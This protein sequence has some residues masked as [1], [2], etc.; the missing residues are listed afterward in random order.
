MLR[1]KDFSFERGSSDEK[2]EET[3]VKSPIFGEDSS[4]KEK[5]QRSVDL[6]P[7]EVTLLKNSD[8]AM[9]DPQLDI[10]NEGRA[11]PIPVKEIKKAGQKPRRILPYLPPVVKELLRWSVHPDQVLRGA[12]SVSYLFTLPVIEEEALPT[13]DLNETIGEPGVLKKKR[14]LPSIP[15]THNRALPSKVRS[16]VEQ[17]VLKSKAKFRRRMLPTLPM[18]RKQMPT[19]PT[20]EKSK[21]IA[22]EERQTTYKSEVKEE[23]QSLE[24]VIGR[25]EHAATVPSV[26]DD[27]PKA[28]RENL[29]RLPLGSNV[30]L[31]VRLPEELPSV[32]AKLARSNKTMLERSERRALHSKPINTR[33][34]LPQITKK[35]QPVQ[36]PLPTVT[37][38][39]PKI[40]PTV[41]RSTPNSQLLVSKAPSSLEPTLKGRSITD[42]PIPGFQTVQQEMRPKPP[43]TSKPNFT[44]PRPQIPVA[45]KPQSS[46]IQVANKQTTSIL[47]SPSPKRIV[48]QPLASVQLD[49][50]CLFRSSAET[51]VKENSKPLLMKSQVDMR[52]KGQLY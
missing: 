24:H 25:Q 50:S 34:V 38:R 46:N 43:L 6:R 9:V 41:N 17:Q 11:P 52:N 33:P 28:K 44:R 4:R 15:T 1:E 12:A 26:P 27:H 5:F 42:R 32:R 48:K 10:E 14:M 2:S 7:T 23:L 47:R 51:T 3:I 20:G 37:R 21:A 22:P 39:Q 29:N 49:E 19:I 36:K 13:A 8:E 16:Q 30:L 18:F 35:E 40:L 31:D 45:Q